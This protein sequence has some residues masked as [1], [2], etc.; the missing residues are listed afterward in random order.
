MTL[1]P[2]P[3]KLT[4]LPIR[5]PNSSGSFECGKHVSDR[6]VGGN[7]ATPFSIPWQVQIIKVGWWDHVCGGTLIPPRQVMTAAHCVVDYKGKF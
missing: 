1:V 7:E 6:I 2:P 3:L 5:Q 4:P